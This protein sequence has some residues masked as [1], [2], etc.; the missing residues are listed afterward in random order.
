MDDQRKESAAKLEA[1]LARLRVLDPEQMAE[2]DKYLNESGDAVF[3]TEVLRRVVD[4]S[5]SDE[6]AERWAAA[7]EQNSGDGK[8]VS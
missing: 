4:G 5:M 8:A 2:I 3:V 6:E 7:M 1:I